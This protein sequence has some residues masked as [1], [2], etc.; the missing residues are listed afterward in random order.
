MLSDIQLIGYTRHPFSTLDEV[1]DTV[2]HFDQQYLEKNPDFVMGNVICAIQSMLTGLGDFD[3]Y[4]N[5]IT[6]TLSHDPNGF[7]YY[8]E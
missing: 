3:V 8:N 4:F 5:R 7:L 1:R 6:D 2:F